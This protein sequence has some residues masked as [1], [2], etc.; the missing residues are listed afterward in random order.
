MRKLGDSYGQA[1]S[2][3][4]GYAGSL[5]IAQ[6]QADRALM[7]GRAAQA[8]IDSVGA[9]LSSA[10]RAASSAG[11]TADLLGRAPAEGALPPDPE[12][13]R[14]SLGKLA[15]LSR[16]GTRGLAAGSRGLTAARTGLTRAASSLRAGMGRR[17][18]V[19]GSEAG[20]ANI[21]VLTLGL[22]RLGRTAPA[23]FGALKPNHIYTHNGA[24]Y[25]TDELGR[26]T[27]VVIPR[28]ARHAPVRD[29]YAQRMVGKAGEPGEPGDQGGH[30]VGARFG[31]SDEGYNL[32]PQNAN[33]NLGKWKAMEND[34][35]R[36]VKAGQDVSVRIRPRYTSEDARPAWFDVESKIDNVERSRRF[37]NAAGGVRP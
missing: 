9:A 1:A 15:G 4:T 16:V 32:V 10:R 29:P 8:E 37:H 5:D 14:A 7:Q 6:E 23:K 26:V 20:S 28:L 2:A 27:D 33:L 3:L 11:S 22:S 34:W 13:V 17:M 25:R 24:T 19:L 35:D 12:Q 36:A 21:D 18:A 30:M 31:G